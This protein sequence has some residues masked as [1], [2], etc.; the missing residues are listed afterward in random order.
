MEHINFDAS[1]HSVAQY[2]T[3]FTQKQWNCTHIQEYEWIVAT[4]C[5]CFNVQISGTVIT[6]CDARTKRCMQTSFIGKG[7]RKIALKVLRKLYDH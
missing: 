4:D 1:T 3:Q 2:L 6:V 7:A 5:Y